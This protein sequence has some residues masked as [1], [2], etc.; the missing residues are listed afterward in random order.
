M[1][2]DYKNIDYTNA[3]ENKYIGICFKNVFFG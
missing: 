1:D 2:I 3:N